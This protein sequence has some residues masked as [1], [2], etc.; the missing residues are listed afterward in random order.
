MQQ[1]E[2]ADEQARYERSRSVKIFLLKWKCVLIISFSL[3]TIMEMVYILVQ[4]ILD[5][6]ALTGRLVSLLE[7]RGN[8]SSSRFVSRNN[9]NTP[10]VNVFNFLPDSE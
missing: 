5:D 8:R 7:M 4:S 9:N 2:A 10:D 6:E 3:I 1:L